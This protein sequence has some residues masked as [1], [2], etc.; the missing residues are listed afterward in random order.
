MVLAVAYIGVTFANSIGMQ[1][2]WVN[3]S[4]GGSGRACH[5]VT[6]R[7]V[8]LETSPGD[9]DLLLKHGV[10][11]FLHQPVLGA[12]VG[13]FA[14]SVPDSLHPDQFY[15]YP[16]NVLVELAAETGVIGLLL[17]FA[18]LVA[19]WAILF[20][21]GVHEGSPQIAV[22]LLIT[23]VFFTVASVSGDIPSDRGL[24]I[25]GIVALK[26]GFD[27]LRRQQERQGLARA[28]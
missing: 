11:M 8:S 24:W 20:W 26:L 6:D 18:P 17:V 1:P 21:R 28:A 2:P 16:H 7:I 5:C 12:G 23:A 4:S 25:F 15:Q 10:Q 27:G 19:G 9:R 13:A 22:I 14:G 3:P